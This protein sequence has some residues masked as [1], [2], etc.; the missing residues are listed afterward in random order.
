MRKLGNQGFCEKRRLLAL[1]ILNQ[2]KSLAEVA[3]SLNISV[4]TLRCWQRRFQEKGLEGLR[5]KRH[6]GNPRELSATLQEAIGAALTQS[7]GSLDIP[8]EKWDGPAICRLLAQ[9]FSIFL[10]PKYIYRWLKK[11]NLGVAQIRPWHRHKE[12]H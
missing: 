12:G 2:G 11:H 9:H 4:P 5:A 8:Q 6:G 1:E 10:H 7:P 3:N